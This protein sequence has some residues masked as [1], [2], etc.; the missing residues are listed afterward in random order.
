MITIS[1]SLLEILKEDLDNFIHEFQ[2][3]ATLYE[4]LIEWIPFNKLKIGDRFFAAWLDGITMP[5]HQIY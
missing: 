3:K 4:Y 1:P 5:F 2:L